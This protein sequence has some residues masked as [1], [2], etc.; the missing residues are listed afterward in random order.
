MTNAPPYLRA[1]LLSLLLSACASHP[2][3]NRPPPPE[4]A[5]YD[6]LEPLNRKVFFLNQRLTKYVIKPALTVYRFIIP[7]P[8]R[9][10]VVRVA[11]N[12]EAP[13]VFI[14]DVL[15]G[16]SDRAFVMLGRFMMN[17]T[18]GIGGLFD[19]ATAAGLPDHSEDAGQTLA[20]WGLPNG[21]Y[22]V[23][24]LIGPTTLRD[25]IGI[26]I[27]IF[28][29]PIRYVLRGNELRN[30]LGVGQGALVAT[31]VLDTKL[32]GQLELE[33]GAIDPYVA[34]RETYRQYRAAEVSNQDIEIPQD[35]PLA[36]ELDAQP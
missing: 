9:Q 31:S 15:Q 7:R 12:V 5:A 30:D 6:P 21:P 26:G 32:D 11:T 14:H 36:A 16:E 34:L 3:L 17:S 2:P 23:L 18:I 10:M 22:F 13:L 4:R 8:V 28:A 20:R 27:D 24:P 29:D 1:L 25:G 33:R 35:D 19:P